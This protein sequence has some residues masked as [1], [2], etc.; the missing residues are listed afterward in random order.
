MGSIVTGTDWHLAA[1]V[2]TDPGAWDTLR[3]TAALQHLYQQHCRTCPVTD[4]C[5]TALIDSGDNGVMRAGH[6]RR[7]ADDTI[8]ALPGV[9]AEIRTT[10]QQP[11]LAGRNHRSLTDDQ[12]QQII[13]LAATMSVRTIAAQFGVSR[14]TIHATLKRAREAA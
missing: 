11:R 4:A 6:Y 3:G 12:R 5:L 7:R 8:H 14:T 1:C 10:N 2:G 13:T 9:P